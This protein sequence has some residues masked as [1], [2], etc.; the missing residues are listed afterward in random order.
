LLA[1]P[2]AIYPPLPTHNAATIFRLFYNG[3]KSGALAVELQRLHGMGEG[4]YR[5][6]AEPA[7]RCRVYVPVARTKT[8]WLFSESACWKTAPIAFVHQPLTSRWACKSVDT[9]APDLRVFTVSPIDPFGTDRQ[10]SRAWI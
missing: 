6:S 1:A 9:A 3:D 4:V 2:D 8:C 10:N 5:G 7:D